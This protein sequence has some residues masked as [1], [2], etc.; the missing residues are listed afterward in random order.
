MCFNNIARMWFYLT[1]L[2]VVF[3]KPTAMD[4][5]F[6]RPIFLWI[7][8]KLWRVW[9]TCPEKDCNRQFLVIFLGI[10]R[11]VD[12]LHQSGTKKILDSVQKKKD[13]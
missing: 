2:S 8:K 3:P 7:P 13:F 9:L 10:Y 4:R 11:R 12:V 5:Y 1:K 6:A